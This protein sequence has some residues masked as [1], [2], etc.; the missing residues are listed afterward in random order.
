MLKA[1]RVTGSQQRAWVRALPGLQLVKAL[2]MPER[3]ICSYGDDTLSS[4][5]S[6]VD[7]EKLAELSQ[8]GITKSEAEAWRPKIANIINWFDQ[9]QQVDLEGVPPALRA[10]LEKEDTLRQDDP[11][12]FQER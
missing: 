7:L 1:V 12:D 8:L 6:A 5:T 11:S 2:R 9:L 4:E 3:R 10:S